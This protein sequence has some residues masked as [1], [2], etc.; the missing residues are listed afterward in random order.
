MK[1][2]GVFLFSLFFLVLL[3]LGGLLYEFSHFSMTRIN[4]HL[5]KSMEEKLLMTRNILEN[6]IKNLRNELQRKALLIKDHQDA[7]IRTSLPPPLSSS[8]SLNPA[9][10]DKTK[11]FPQT[12][13]QTPSILADSPFCS[14]E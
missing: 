11:N 7:L 14:S 5:R 2:Q 12:P 6:H 9:S 13:P 8:S 1:R 3:M 10:Q 4:F